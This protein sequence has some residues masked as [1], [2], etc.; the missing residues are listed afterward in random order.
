M[1]QESFMVFFKSGLRIG[2]IVLLSSSLWRL[3]DYIIQRYALRL[4][5]LREVDQPDG[6]IILKTILPI[7]RSIGKW[8]LIVITGILVL[9]ELHIDVTPILLS[10]SVVG[11]AFSM[12][13]QTL[14]KDL[15]NGILALFEGNLAVGQVIQVGAKKG[16][17]ESM[18]LRCIHLR[19]GNGELETIPFSE[20]TSITNLSRDYMIVPFSIMVEPTVDLGVVEDIFK[21]TFHAMRD[22]SHFQKRIKGNLQFSGVEEISERGVLLSASVRIEPDPK[23]EF[24]RAFYTYLFKELQKANIPLARNRG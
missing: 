19:H 8:V 12:G 9:S 24:E 7:A 6:S 18:S 21:K 11:L 13:S 5:L 15:I 14:V 16:V 10:F 1:D 20:V 2:V 23:K 17:V 4:P 3:L 22:L